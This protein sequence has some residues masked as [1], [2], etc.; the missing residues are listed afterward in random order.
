MSQLH[1]DVPECYLSL[2]QLAGKAC[3]LNWA[4]SFISRI[5]GARSGPYSSVFW[6]TI[7]RSPLKFNRRFGGTYCLLLQGPNSKLSF[8]GADQYVFHFASNILRVPRTNIPGL[9]TSRRSERARRLEVAWT[10]YSG[11]KNKQDGRMDQLES[12]SVALVR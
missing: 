3:L 1:A 4:I 8:N 11:S 10:R 5:L 6:D 2:V 7:P 12:N 9:L